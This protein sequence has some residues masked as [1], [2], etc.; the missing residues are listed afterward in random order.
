MMH[1]SRHL[2]FAFRTGR[3]R[4]TC[5]T[6]QTC[7]AHIASRSG[8]TLI[9]LISVAALATILISLAVAGYH[10][11]TRDNAMVAGQQMFKSALVRARSY[12]LSHRCETR[13]L[14]VL[15]DPA[16]NRS[17]SFTVEFRTNATSPWLTIL[18][19][20][21]LPDWVFFDEANPESFTEI[22]FRKNGSCYANNSFS[23]GDT[24]SIGW[25]RVGIFH[26]NA[27]FKTSAEIRRYQSILEINRRTGLVREVLP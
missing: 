8:Y 7:A 13:A 23:T 1:I 14:S 25:I 5:R 21:A 3:T 11:W 22:L 27:K 18:P 15:N 10:T 4:R 26:A 16:K 9:E 17:A 2:S 20:N 24:E 6:C 12:A 19:T